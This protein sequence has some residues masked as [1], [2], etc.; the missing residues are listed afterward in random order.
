[1]VSFAGFSRQ[2]KSAKEKEEIGGGLELEESA[3]QEKED[4]DKSASVGF[5]VVR[6]PN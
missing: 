6:F 1:M 3:E 2:G 5:D 4:S